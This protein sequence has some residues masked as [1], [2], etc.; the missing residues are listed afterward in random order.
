[1]WGEE[2]MTDLNA[3]NQ[4][5]RFVYSS[6]F[7]PVVLICF[8]FG[9]SIIGNKLQNNIYNAIAIVIALGVTVISYFPWHQPGS[10]I[11]MNLAIAFV[12]TV[13]IFILNF[14]KL[15]LLDYAVLFSWFAYVTRFIGFD[16]RFFGAALPALYVLISIWLVY[17]INLKQL[18][19]QLFYCWFAFILTFTKAYFIHYL[20]WGHVIALGQAR[21]SRIEALLIWGAA[22][23]TAV[24]VSALVIYTIKRVFKKHFDN[25]NKMGRTYPQIEKFFIYNSLI[26]IVLIGASYY[27]YGMATVFWPNPVLDMF[28]LLLLFVMMLQLSFLI[29]IFRITWLKDNLKNKSLENQSLAAYSSNLEKNINDIAHIKHDIKNI[30]LTMGNFVEKSGIKEM[31]EFY[32]EKINPFASDEIA[33][34][35]LY[36]KLAGID[37]EQLKAFLFYKISQAIKRGVDVE[38]DILFPSIN[39]NEENSI[40]FVDLVRI[41][42]ILLDNAIEECMELENGSISI[43]ITRNSELVSYMISNFVRD[44]VKE[45]G[46]RAGISTKGQ[47]RGKGLV[48]VCNIIDKYDFVTLNSY[49]RDGYFVQNIVVYS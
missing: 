11:M 2:S 13:T 15:S 19:G 10:I 25:I 18:R 32:Q 47:N 30:F 41:L 42:G 35:D 27:I 17:K 49:F 8:L 4:I 46:I 45:M 38:L 3:I 44:E 36:A 31:Q 29:L 5:L 48:N 16:T 24:V 39:S 1:M 20:F 34:S 14:V 28:N 23:F 9:L 40:E 12:M 33:K 6:T 26:I 21:H 22:I 7:P 43:K 37:N